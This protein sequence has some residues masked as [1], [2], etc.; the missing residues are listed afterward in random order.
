[1]S[2]TALQRRSTA[3]DFCTREKRKQRK[4]IVEKIRRDRI[5]ASIDKL[6]TL[7]C[8]QMKEKKPS[9]KLEKADILEVTVHFLKEKVKCSSSPGCK[10]GFSNCLQETFSY[11]P[12]HVPQQ[13][14]EQVAIRS[15][16]TDQGTTFQKR[17]ATTIK[18][19]SAAGSSLSHQ[20][21]Q[22]SLWRPWQMNGQSAMEDLL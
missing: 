9:L 8:K 17:A 11:L 6:K 12:L 21:C 14:S 4:P 5:N 18:S 10:K 1:M 7:L 13:P 22:G 3:L 19:S 16:T 15:F 2:P 20:Q